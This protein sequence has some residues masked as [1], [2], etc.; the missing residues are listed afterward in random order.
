MS[1]RR[2]TP[3]LW[4]SSRRGGA[5]ARLCGAGA[6]GTPVAEPV[7][8]ERAESAEP[9]PE[10]VSAAAMALGPYCGTCSQGYCKSPT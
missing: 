3:W 9:E 5:V 8:D 6:G 2:L 1:R 7:A 4:G 10:P